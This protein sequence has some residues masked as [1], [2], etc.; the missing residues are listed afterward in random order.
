MK[1]GYGNMTIGRRIYFSFGVLWVLTA[2]VGALGMHGITEIAGLE[3]HGISN[4]AGLERVEGVDRRAKR[5]M[6]AILG[7]ST[8]LTL[9]L[10]VTVSGSI[11]SALK[12]IS[13]EMDKAASQIDATTYQVSRASKSLARGVSGQA[14]AVRQTMASLA[15]MASM[16][17]QTDGNAAKADL[18]IAETSQIVVETVESVENLMTSIKEISRASDDTQ[19]IV[20]AIDEI[21]FQ[22]N[23]L[24][25][26]AA[27]E[28]ARAGEAGAGF[29]VVATEVRRLA[30]RAAEAAGRTAG[31]IED[32][33]AKVAIGSELVSGTARAFSRI[34]AKT[35]DARDLV[36]G[37]AEASHEQAR[38]VDQIAAAMSDVEKVTDENQTNA[39]RSA[40]V[41][42]KLSGE[43]HFLR[44]I[45]GS[46][47]SLVTMGADVPE[48]IVDMK[49]K[50]LRDL[51][52]S[53]AITK[54][55]AS[56]HRGVLGRWL[57]EH[58]EV[59]AVY[60]N[61][62]DGAFIY[63]EPPAGLP[64]AGVR[65]WWQRAMADEEYVSPV[66]ISAI[67][68][69]PCCTLSLPIHDGGGEPVGVLGIDLKVA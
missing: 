11:E 41:S 18:L 6:L 7:L 12:G 10:A 25:L 58:P 60:T 23:L 27:V 13:D 48:E 55:D 49:L 47:I 8:A 24:A 42:E 63:S 54:L 29:A 45:I 67:T 37:I 69:K 17:K 57:S 16:V 28:A 46:L 51:A 39:E 61:R 40:S 52:R 34:A 31:M 33:V 38:E 14:A 50:L 15:Q 22:T 44:S 68:N 65:P 32:T 2:S 9:L 59:E 62:N 36:R 3:R 66:Y 4:P 1:M 35:N 19:K 56:V 20:K 26:N 21:A 30:T 5:N 43:G 53:S 64:N